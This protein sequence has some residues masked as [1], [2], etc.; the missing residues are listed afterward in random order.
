MPGHQPRQIT[1]D[2]VRAAMQLP[3]PGLLAQARM[4]PRRQPGIEPVQQTTQ[5]RGAAVLVLIYAID[6][7]LHLVLT[8]RTETVQNHKGQISLPGGA[9][10]AGESLIQTALREANEELAI[11]T[12]GLEIL[13]TLSDI[14]VNVSNY[15]ITPVVA[16]A[17]A[18]PT[19][20]PD[21]I[22]VTAVIEMP[23]SLL[24]DPPARGEEDWEVRGAPVHVPFFIVGQHKVWGATAMILAE[25]AH[26]LEKAAGSWR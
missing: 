13:G 25:F 26:L 14:Y 3:R 2:D 10:E 11:A 21:P 20:H 17:P 23:L 4:L 6:G 9:Q 15:L 22:E 8:R 7:A 1:L 24:L 5:A 16:L 19:F 12:D 18:R